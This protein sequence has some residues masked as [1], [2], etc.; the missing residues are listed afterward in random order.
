MLQYSLVMTVSDQYASFGDI[1]AAVLQMLV[2][3]RDIALKTFDAK[4]VLA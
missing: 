4:Q 2:R 1:G 3:S